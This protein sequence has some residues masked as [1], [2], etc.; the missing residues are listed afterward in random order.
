MSGLFFRGLRERFW[1][2]KRRKLRLKRVQSRGL[3]LR[4]RDRSCRVVSAAQRVG[5]R[6]YST[7][8]SNYRSR[9]RAARARRLFWWLQGKGR[10][11]LGEHAWGRPPVLRKKVT[12][13]L[14]EGTQRQKA[15]QL[16][17]VQGIAE[18]VAQLLPRRA[19]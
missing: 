17:D 10:D 16:G 8:R 12:V 5:R 6:R 14:G 9:S 19:T 15:A 3:R 2:K 11:L 4:A 18:L 1:P 13:V 7:R